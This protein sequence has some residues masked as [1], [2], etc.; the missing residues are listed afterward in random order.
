MVD[1]QLGLIRNFKNDEQLKRKNRELTDE[2]DTFRDKL[3][4]Y[5][6][7]INLVWIIYC[8]LA[9]NYRLNL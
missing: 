7:Y 2:M 8:T 6:L 5:Y 3:Y 1:K 4:G 9:Q